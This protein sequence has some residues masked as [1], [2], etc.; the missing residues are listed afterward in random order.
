[1]NSGDSKVGLAVLASRVVSES[2]L[3]HEFIPNQMIFAQVVNLFELLVWKL[4]E[5]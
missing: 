5:S 4:L 2:E 3:I 1:M